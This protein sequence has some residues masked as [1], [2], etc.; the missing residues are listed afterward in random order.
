MELERRTEGA[1]M[2]EQ[3]RD[4]WGLHD[5]YPH[6]SGALPG[7]GACEHRNAVMGARATIRSAGNRISKHLATCTVCDIRRSDPQVCEQIRDTVTAHDD[8]ESLIAGLEE[9]EGN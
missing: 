1:G 5:D 8:A 3:R 4:K 7:C 9:L 6:E 2:G